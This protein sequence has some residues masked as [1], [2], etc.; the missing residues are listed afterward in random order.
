MHASVLSI[1][2]MMMPLDAMYNAVLSIYQVQ[3]SHDDI[4]AAMPTMPSIH[5]IHHQLQWHLGHLGH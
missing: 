1:Q 4:H 5:L 2:V 3:L